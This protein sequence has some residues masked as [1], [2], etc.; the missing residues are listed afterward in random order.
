MTMMRRV[1]SPLFRG[2]PFLSA[3]LLLA[4]PQDSSAAPPGKSEQRTSPDQVPQGLEKSDWSS[5]L[6]AHSAWEHSFQPVKGGAWQAQNKA[7]QWST[8]FDGRGFMAKPK[9]ADWQWGLELRSYGF[10]KKQTAVG[11]QPAVKAE[12]QRL[13]YQWNADVQEWFVNDQR[14]LEHGFTVAR[15]PQGAAAKASLDMVLGTRGTLKASVAADTQTVYFRD[16]QGAPVVTYAG[17]KVWDADGKVLPSRFVAGPSGGIILRVDESSARY[18]ITIDPIAQQAYLKPNAVGTT[19]AGD[20]FGASVAVSGDTVVVGAFKEDSSTT[21]VNSTPNESAADAGA[22]YVFVRSGST[23]SQ[24]AYLK[25]SQVTAGD[26][27]GY[28]VA[29]SGDTLVVGATF[30]DSNTTG[31]GSTPNESASAAGAAYVFVRSGTTWSQQAYLKASQVTLNDW[32][33]YSVSVSGNT[34]VVGSFFED[35]STTGVG[36]TPNE[37][38][39]GAGAAYVFVRSGTTWSQ[40]AY[41]KASQVSVDDGFGYSAS[42][43][44]DTVVVGALYEDSSTTGV[45][46]TPNESASAAGAAYVF[47]RSGTTWSQQAYL[48]ASQVSAS[49]TFGYALAVSGDTLVVGAYQEDSSTT[50]V[51]STPNE[52]TSGAGAA[53]VFARSGT[54]WSQQ[55]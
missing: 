40:Q 43:S 12:G 44:G 16:D 32:F 25:A 26:Q 15:R 55:A 6:A 24:Q 33:G 45:N 2:L 20:T 29:L 41:L 42:V 18:P 50:G 22:V 53:Y 49:D 52:S 8:Q 31:V 14:G 27:F 13:S 7:Q 1:L 51:N 10:G 37:S 35:S 36:S 4:V 48:K 47:V 39:S 23:W 9:A 5:I 21:G 11:G 28:S 17:L 30:E 34:V 3:A 46:S 38:A 54:T 19:Q